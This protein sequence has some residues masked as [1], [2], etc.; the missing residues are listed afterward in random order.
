MLS[1]FSPANAFSAFSSFSNNSG[2][3]NS[4]AATSN[5]GNSNS[6]PSLPANSNQSSED[7]TPNHDSIIPL[8]VGLIHFIG[9]GGIG[10]SGI[11]ELL[12]RLG[13][14]VQGSDQKASGN[15]D[16]LTAAGVQVF[17]GHQADNLGEA[18]VVVVSSAI[19]AD[20]PELMAAREARLPIVQRAEMLGELMRFRTGISVAGTHG[21]TTTTSLLAH[22]LQ[23]T[24]LEP[25]AVIGGV[26]NAYGTNAWLGKGAYMVVE[27]DES[28]GSFLRLPSGIAIVTNIDPEHM[29]HYGSF[30]NVIDSYAEFIRKLPFNGFAVVCLD[31]PTVREQLMPT[32]TTRHVLTYGLSAQAD[33]RAVNVRYDSSGIYY[34]ISVRTPRALHH[35][36]VHK[37]AVQEGDLPESREILRGFHLPMIGEH[38]LLNSLA[39]ITVALQIGV[40]PDAIRTALDSFAGVKRRFTPTGTWNGVRFFDDYG[41]HP[42]EISAV[43]SAA[44]TALQ[45]TSTENDLPPRI[46]AIVQPHRYTRLRDLFT[47]FCGCFHNADTVIVADVYTAGEDPIQGFDRQGLVQGI[48]EHGHGH[49]ISLDIPEDLAGHLAKICTSGDYVIFLGAGTITQWA[50]SIAGDMVN[51]YPKVL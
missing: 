20:N 45:H 18:S 26:V 46:V 1:A 21:K 8:P 35:G 10:M 48:R 33:V 16:R 32:I 2:Q 49:V 37:T 39:V 34:D 14:R 12:A 23:Q 4:S 36:L 42:N 15:T 13:H 27:A 25:T 47:E 3:S 9:V 7:N 5:A 30:E 44:K 43:L 38:N 41:H 6:I 28:D 51:C 11:A 50:A 22:V 24:G 29:E 17:I 40:L 31:H 19:K